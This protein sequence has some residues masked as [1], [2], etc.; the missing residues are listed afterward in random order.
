MSTPFGKNIHIFLSGENSPYAVYSSR[1]ATAIDSGLREQSSL[2]ATDCKIGSGEARDREV[3]VEVRE[4]PPYFCGLTR[5]PLRA[6]QIHS[7]RAGIRRNIHLGYEILRRAEQAL[8][9]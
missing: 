7:D 4:G 1:R 9:V 5:Q 3:S 2:T 8:N 6:G